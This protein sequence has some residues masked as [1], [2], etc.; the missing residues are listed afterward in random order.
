MRLRRKQRTPLAVC[1]T[2]TGEDQFALTVWICCSSPCLTPSQQT[3]CPHCVDL[4]LQPLS[5][6]QSANTV[7]S[8]CGSAVPAL[9][10]PPVSKHG[11]VTVWIC[12]SS[13][14]LTPSQQTRCPHCVD[15]LLQPLS[16][17]QSANT[18]P[19]LCGS[20]APAL[21]LPPVSKHGALTVWICCSSP[22]LTPSQQTRCPHCVDLLL[23][24]LSYPQSANTVPSLCG[25]AAPAL[26]LPPVSKHGALTVWICCSSPCLTPSQQTRCPHCVDLLLQPLSYPQ[27]ANTVPSLCGS[28]VPAL[29]LPPVRK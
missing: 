3:R 11:A 2:V 27:S 5:Y 20:A 1:V 6:P 7:P 8:L 16:Y 15:L 25:S 19:S 17:P 24:P 22:C 29:V 18:V 26:V 14:C 21:V 10:L 9:V 28:A 4:L 23:Q 12:C 13:P